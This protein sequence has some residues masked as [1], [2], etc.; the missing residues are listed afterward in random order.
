MIAC[1]LGR[2]TK[3]PLF[4]PSSLPI[5]PCTSIYG[6]FYRHISRLIL[7]KR[8]WLLA[9]WSYS[10]A[11]VCIQGPSLAQASS[12]CSPSKWNTAPSFKAQDQSHLLLPRPSLTPLAWK[13]FPCRAS[14]TPRIPPSYSILSG[15]KVICVPFYAPHQIPL[16][17][18]HAGPQ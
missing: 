14:E 7:Q 18:P 3:L 12:P 11:A 4:S 10:T 8:Q 5:Q 17:T 16:L 1:P 9:T 13:P 15:E 6:V 2:Y